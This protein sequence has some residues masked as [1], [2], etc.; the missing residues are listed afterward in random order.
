MAIA[1]DVTDVKRAVDALLTLVCERAGETERSRR[2]PDDVAS[3]IRDAGINR[4]ALPAALGGLEAPV[5]DMID[6]FERIAAVDGSTGWCAVIGA[7]SNFFA[8]YLPEAGAREVFADPDQGNATMV[9]PTGKVVADGGHHRLSGRWPFTSNC[10]HSRWAGLGALIQGPDGVDPVPRVVFVR[11]GEVTIED[12]WDSVGLRGT[13]SHHVSARDVATGRDHWC[14]FSDRPWPEGTLWRLPLSTVLFPT[15]VAVLLGVARGAMDEVARQAREGR[16]A[17]RGQ[18]ADD[19]ISMAEFAAAD[20]R[21]RG[22]RAG[23][24]EAVEEAHDRAERGDSL[25]RRLQARAGLAS[26]HAVDTAVE[27]TSTAHQLGGGAAAY[28]GSRLLRALVDVE[29]A[30]QHLLFAPVH[31]VELGRILAGHDAP[32]PPFV[33]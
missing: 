8:G 4:L 17:R 30:R 9:A 10:L 21:L 22:A 23:L 33:S 25:D 19:P 15:L 6:L 2:L 14:A 20:A 27:V 32:Y 12:T 1:S 28:T 18:L 7:S 24:R 5:A 3:A 16:T 11:V 13:G 29:A 26:L 31:R